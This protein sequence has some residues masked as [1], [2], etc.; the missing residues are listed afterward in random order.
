MNIETIAIIISF[1]AIF[2][3]VGS[4]AWVLYKVSKEL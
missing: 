3:M 1:L 2:I 4:I